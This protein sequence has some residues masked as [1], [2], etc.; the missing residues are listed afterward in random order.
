[1]LSN[2]RSE[3][4]IL[5]SLASSLFNGIAQNLYL[6]AVGSDPQPAIGIM[7]MF[8]GDFLGCLIL[9]LL[10]AWTTKSIRK[11]VYAGKE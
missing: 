7:V 3:N 4:L 10:L 6:I 8:I 9:L 11:Y 1:M 2:L 5:M